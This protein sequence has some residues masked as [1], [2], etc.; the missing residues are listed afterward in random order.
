MTTSKL[1]HYRAELERVIDGDTI[2]CTLDLG[3][4]IHYKVRIRFAGINAPESR[5]RDL[6]EKQKGLESK[7]F[8]EN[9][10]GACDEVIVQ[11]RLDEKGKFG[12][13]LGNILNQEGAC[14]NHEMIALGHA[15][16]YEGG[17]RK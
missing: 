14:L 17:K 7:Q 8:V 1:F 2:D 4:D 3:F 10:L 9:W 12:R 6:V 13:V 11:T 16:V 5:T 15:T